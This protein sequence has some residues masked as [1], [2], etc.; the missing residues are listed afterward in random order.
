MTPALPNLGICLVRAAALPLGKRLQ[1]TLGG[2][3]YLPWQDPETA[4]RE[5]FARHFARHTH[6]IL[7]MASGIAVRFLDG[8][9]LDKHQDPAVVVLDE[10]ARFAI[11]LLSGHEGGANALAYQIGRAIGA[12][13]VITTASEALKP[14]VLG[15]GCRRGASYAQIAAAVQLT[16]AGSGA[17]RSLAEVREVATVDLKAD[18]AGLLEFCRRHELP[19]RIFTRAQL[20]ARPWTDRPSAWVQEKIG[21]DGVCEPCALLAAERGTLLVPKTT[22]DGV[23]VALASD[24]GIWNDA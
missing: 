20:A 11:S 15:I 13:P 19:L 17:P 16:L 21:L 22:L 2:T 5:Q 24:A 23:A 14:L 12:L 6:W 18:E 1:A 3:L 4:Q 10:A 8:L 7:I 9:P